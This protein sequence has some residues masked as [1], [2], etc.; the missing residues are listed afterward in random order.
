M[1]DIDQLTADCR[2]ALRDHEPRTAVKEVLE[3]AVSAPGEVAAALPVNRAEIVP[4]YTSAELSV[5]KVV[6]APGMRF[7]PHNH[8]M[9]AA[10]ALYGGAEDNAFYRR[11]DG[12]LEPSGGRRLATGDVALLGDDTI[13]AVTN[14]LGTFTGA[15]HVYGGDI[16]CRPG[17][18]EWE[19]PEYTEIPYDFDR[20]KQTFE[21]A[22]SML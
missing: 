2:E 7:G 3:R 9:W 4:L 8:L 14:P 12:G 18:R 11:H 21:A 20:T 22:N 19:E 17:R 1:F 6:W 10:I 16:T 5:L 13:H 15:I